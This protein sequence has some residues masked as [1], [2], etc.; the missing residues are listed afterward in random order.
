MKKVKKFL[1]EIVYIALA[2]AIISNVISYIRKPDLISPNL[3]L[4]DAKQYIGK[5]LLVHFW[6][7]WCYY[8][9]KEIPHLNEIY[10]KYGNQGMTILAVS[11]DR[12][13]PDAVRA[14]MK[15]IK[16][17][18]PVVMGNPKIQA[19]FG[20]IR[21]LPTTFVISPDWQVKRVH[22]GYVPKTVLESSIK[23]LLKQSS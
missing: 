6:A 23:E 21:G 11:L 20:N 7:T 18:Y 16:I 2:I 10:A 13:G 8:C 9:R 3:A 14:L 19:N 22:R 4:I 17:D 1:K 12:N 5:P 15:K